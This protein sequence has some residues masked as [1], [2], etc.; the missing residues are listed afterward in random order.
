MATTPQIATSL[1][2]VPEIAAHEVQRPQRGWI[3]WLTTTDH[4]RIGIMYLVASWVFFMV[5]GVEALIMRLQL[6]QAD[7]TLVTPQTY[8][9]LVTMH[10]TT[11]IFLF[12]IPMIAG[13]SNYI[14]PLMIGARDMAFPRLNALSF[15]LFLAGGAAFYGS[16]LWSP[17][18]CGWTCYAPLSE[19]TYS[20]TAGVDSW[21][22]LVHLTGISSFVGALNLFVTIT[23]MRA[24]GMGWGRLPL[25]CWAILTQSI[26]LLL[27]LPVIAAAVTLLLT[28]RHFGT[29]FY[30]A[31]NGGS[32][33]LW[34]HLFWFFGHPEVYILVLPAF[35]V[36]SEILPV[37]ARKP[38]FG[39]KAIAAATLGIAFIGSLV[40]AHHMFTTPS[41]FILLVFFM[42]GSFL[43]AIPTGVKMFNWIFTLW[44]G[45]I[46]FDTPMY[47]AAGFLGTFLLGGVTGI[48]LAA[49]PVDWAL[50]DTYFVVAHFHYT[51]VGGGVFGMLAALYYWFPKM[52]GRM[53]NERMGKTS[54]WLILVGFWVT[55]LVQHSAGLS[56]MP[57]RIYE[58]PDIGN[59]EIYNL[60]ST[61]GAFILAAGIVLTGFNVFRSLRKGPAAGADPWKG[62]TLEWFTTSPP[63]ANNFDAVPRVRSVEPMK[64]I[65]RQIEGQ[66]R[67]DE[68]VGAGAGHSSGD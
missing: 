60:I 40:W 9:A 25:F 32:P 61:I 68:L 53:L 7:N 5:G 26:L 33:L 62:N 56:G 50:H 14:V 52:S 17:P 54:F 51:I 63:P 38:I 24:P 4:K 41:P 66:S 43:V 35:G 3:S 49:F 36:I 30:D 28:D 64:D 31:T 12:L 13:F 21:I 67:T 20:P 29:H 42:L 15:W 6:A 44:R 16:L 34:Q 45:S 18:E 57:R 1:T 48:F 10:G 65:R 37:F 39:Y 23:N 8:N 59:L 22:F 58:Y 55:F 47:F 19:A 46:H 27:A 11:M 2:P